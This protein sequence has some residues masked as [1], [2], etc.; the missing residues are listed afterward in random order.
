MTTP[1]A[2]QI[3]GA[4]QAIKN[5]LIYTGNGKTPSFAMT[6]AATNGLFD[7]ILPAIASLQTENTRLKAEVE[8]KDEIGWLVEWRTKTDT[9]WWGRSNDPEMAGFGW[10]KDS[11]AALRFARKVD[12]EMYIEETGWTDGI[13][14]TEHS[15]PA[16]APLPE[17]LAA[18]EPQVCEACGG[19]GWVPPY[20]AIVKEKCPTC[21]GTGVQP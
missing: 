10:T 1:T 17:P 5:L 9:V 20:N 18:P 13:E 14:A 12:A 8:R 15:W 2:E 3:D 7:V 6:C 19:D 21:N 11:N 16:L 4:T